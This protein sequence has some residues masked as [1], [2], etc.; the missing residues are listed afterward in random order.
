[1]LFLTQTGN[2]CARQPGK[3]RRDLVVDGGRN[4]SALYRICLDFRELNTCL[5]FPQQTSFTTADEIIFK[6]RNKVVVSM[7]ISSA[8]FIIPIREEDRYKT[9]FWVNNLAFEFNVAVMGLKSS[10]YHLNK[11]IERA[12]DAETLDSGTIKRFDPGQN[13]GFLGGL[14]VL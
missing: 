11:F 10:P 3:P 1:M 12:F 7:D 6:L 8:F 4:R 13:L 5:E 2:L 14:Q 9:A